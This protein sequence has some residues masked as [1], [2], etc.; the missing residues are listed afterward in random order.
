MKPHVFEEIILPMLATTKGKSMF[1][2]SPNG[3][4]HFYE[5]YMRGQIKDEPS[6]KSWLYTTLEGGFV[7]ADEIEE[8]K[9]NMDERLFKQE[10]QASFETAG[11][12]AVYNFDIDK[13]VK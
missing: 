8:A 13:H 3:F 6:W 10:F 9:R 2:G 1:I 12:R 5:V 11:R 7:S 4:N